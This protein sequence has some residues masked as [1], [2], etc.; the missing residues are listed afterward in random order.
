MSR[1]SFTLDTS[2]FDAEMKRLEKSMDRMDDHVED[3]CKDVT[4]SAKLRVP[5]DTGKLKMS[6]RYVRHG[7][8]RFSIDA[9]APHA[10]YVENGTSK[11]PAQPFMRPAINVHKPRLMNKIKKELDG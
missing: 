5:V 9:D 11:M 3:F 8:G 10:S 4:A 2:Q 1:V 6:I 7:K